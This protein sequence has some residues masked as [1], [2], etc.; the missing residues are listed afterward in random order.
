MAPK[1]KNFGHSLANAIAAGSFGVVQCT[2]MVALAT[3][4][5]ETNTWDVLD[6]FP[7]LHSRAREA[8]TGICTEVP[9]SK[10]LNR[11]EIW[12]LIY[13]C[14]A[15]LESFTRDPIGYEGSE[16]DLY[17]Y[18]DSSPLARID[19]D[20]ELA[21]PAICATLALGG[22]GCTLPCLSVCGADA[23]CL[24]DCYGM[25]ST[26]GKVVC[27]GAILGLAACIC[28]AAGPVCATPLLLCIKNPKK[29]LPR[30]PP[31]R[32]PGCM[33]CAPVIMFTNPIGPV[34]EQC[35]EM[36]RLLRATP[37]PP[38][39]CFYGCPSRPGNPVVMPN[40]PL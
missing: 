31:V 3:N 15:G 39:S 28:K 9:H 12:L 19:P 24:Y 23:Q 4:T 13:D 22:L 16:W 30:K 40:F 32:K 21:V 38:C 7:K 35:P 1:R 25:M 8:I 29:C 14:R 27:G 26:Y 11:V 10:S 37:T 6:G 18:C 36:C 5:S 33:P 20:G 17:E 34:A 2:P